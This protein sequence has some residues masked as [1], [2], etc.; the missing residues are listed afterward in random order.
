[1]ETSVIIAGFTWWQ[2]GWHSHRIRWRTV[3]LFHSNWSILS[4]C[5]IKSNGSWRL[6]PVYFCW[7]M[8]AISNK[9]KMAV[10]V[11][12]I[13]TKYKFKIQFRW[14]HVLQVALI[15]HSS[16]H[17]SDPIRSGRIS[18]EIS[19]RGHQIGAGTF[20]G[21]PRGKKKSGSCEKPVK[22]GQTRETTRS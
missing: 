9:I 16:I 18:G 8:S 7:N 3:N 14:L 19:T 17:S 2:F 1:M 10:L 12:R 5:S 15:L 6:G 20:Y 11:E 4:L 22:P 21:K 13:P